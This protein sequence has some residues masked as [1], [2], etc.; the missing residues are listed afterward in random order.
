MAE[1]LTELRN[2]QIF[3]INGME[4]V[5]LSRFQVHFTLMSEPKIGGGTASSVRSHVQL[6]NEVQRI[7][8]HGSMQAYF[9][10]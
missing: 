8:S 3:G 2:Y 7:I 9:C 6:G 5:F 4:K 1:I 10:L